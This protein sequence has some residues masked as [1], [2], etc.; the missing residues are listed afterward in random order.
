MRKLSNEQMYDISGG[1]I[2]WDAVTSDECGRCYA[3][4]GAMALVAASLAQDIAAIIALNV[5]YIPILESKIGLYLSYYPLIN[6]AYQENC[7]PCF[8]A[9]GE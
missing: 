1:K 5:S 2:N 3:T 7:V 6:E 9:I 8:A 4:L